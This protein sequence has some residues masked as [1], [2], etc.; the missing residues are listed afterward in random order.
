[1][2]KMFKYRI[3]LK[4]AIEQKLCWTLTRCREL[5][6][7]ALSERKDAYKYAGQSR[8]YYDQ[9][10][11]L[12]EI[13]AEIRPEY[14]E[15][16][17]HVLQDVLKRLDKAFQNFFRRIKEGQK[18]GYPR[19]QGRNRYDSFT[20]PDGAGWKLATQKRPPE[21]KGMVRANLNLSKIGTVKL[22]LHRNIVGTIKTL[23]IKREGE[24]W[25]AILSCEIEKP[26]TLPNS[27]EDVGIDLGVTHFAAL[28]DGTFIESSRHYRLAENKLKKVQGA[29]ARKKRGSHRRK[30]AVQ[31]IAKV[32]RKV[33]NQR[34]DFA[35]KASRQLVNRYQVIVFEDLKTANLVRRPKPKRDEETGQ[36]VPNGA[37][38]KAGL[39]KSIM[40][41]GW[42]QFVEM[43]T[44]KAAW[45]GRTLLK[46]S[47]KYTSQICP[48]CGTLRKKTLEERW[49]SCACGCELDRDTAS[50]KVILDVGHQT[51]LGGTRPTSATASKPLPFGRG[52]SQRTQT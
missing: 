19:F 36:Y 11:D 17:A 43:C 2:R 14:Q 45:A 12:P 49:H 24:H 38:A 6:N 26:E 47:P 9:Q 42:S 33:R 8:S 29:L 3:Y 15:I 44:Y 48:N 25:Y 16:G 52:A 50:A 41:A 34:T 5:Y 51:F 39:N 27:Y 4:K 35:H 28:S 30:K 21:K 18:P 31:A 37:A 10:N 40:D 46:V 1:M 32:H 22:H 23:T 7:A 13:K 20:Y